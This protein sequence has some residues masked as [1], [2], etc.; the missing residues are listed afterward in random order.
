MP[1]LDSYEF[2]YLLIKL[3]SV[4]YKLSDGLHNVFIHNDKLSENFMRYTVYLRLSN[5]F[6]E[7]G[8]ASS[9]SPSLFVYD[10]IP[11][12]AVRW[13]SRIPFTVHRSTRLCGV[14]SDLNL[15]LSL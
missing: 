13:L 12:V 10:Q 9:D 8:I 1:D 14:E 11:I 6:L 2:K 5:I 7:N 15:Y 4:T 3:C